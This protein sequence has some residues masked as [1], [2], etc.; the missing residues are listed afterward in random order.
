MQISTRDEDFIV[1]T[2]E[3]RGEMYILNEAFTDPSI[4]KVIEAFPFVPVPCSVTQ[5]LSHWY[6]I[7]NLGKKLFN[8]EAP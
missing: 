6:S 8:L 7:E 3:L 5:P 2:L 4:V 1:D